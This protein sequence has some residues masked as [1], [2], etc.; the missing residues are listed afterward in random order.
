[1]YKI[2]HILRVL[3]IILWYYLLSFQ[4]N[5]QDT[6]TVGSS[7]IK[8]VGGVPFFINGSIINLDS[9][10]FNS[11]V[12]YVKGD[13]VNNHDGELFTKGETGKVILIGDSIQRIAGIH[14]IRFNKLI[15]N[16]P[17]TVKLDQDIILSDSAFFVRGILDLH[18]N[19]MLLDNS[20]LSVNGVL[21][22]EKDTS[23]IVGDSGYVWSQ[24]PL[25]NY[26]AKNGLGLGLILG[27]VSGGDLKIER[28]HTSELTVTDGSIKKYF[29]LYPS[30]SNQDAE[31]TFYY[32]DADLWGVNCTESDFKLWS[33]YTEGYYY[34]HKYGE[35][36]TAGNYAYTNGEYINLQNQVRIT[37][38]DEICDNPPNVNLGDDT[39]HVCYED[40]AVLDA[41]NPGYDFMWNTGATT[42]TIRVADAGMYIVTV[43][44]PK[45]CFTI[46]SIV[47][48]IDS[49]PHPGFDFAN[50]N[51]KCAGDT[52]LFTNNSTA[53][54]S[55]LPLSYQW[56]FGDGTVSYDSLPAKV[57]IAG[58][59]YEITL[60]AT[61]IN[62]CQRSVSHLAVVK[63][64]P[65]VDF[66]ADNVCFH[67]TV[68]F[69]NSTSGYIMN[70][71]WYFGDGDSST[72]SNPSHIYDTT[73]N[74]DV[75]LSVTNNYG[76][77]SSDTQT[78]AVYPPGTADFTT[79]DANVCY[80][81]S[82]V[83]HN[84]SVSPGGSMTYYWDFGNGLSSTVANPIILYDSVAT[85]DVMLV[86]ETEHGCKDT[87]IKQVTV[88][89]QPQPDFLYDDVCMG[90]SVYFTNASSIYPPEPMSFAWDF[91]DGTTSTDSNATKYYDQQGTYTVILS[92]TSSHGCQASVTKSVNVYPVPVANFTA[93]SVCYGEATVFHNLTYPD[94]VSMNF[95][96]DFGDGNTSNDEEPQHF[97]SSDGQYTVQ[98]IAV[99]GAG[100]SD[101]IVKQVKVF[102]VPVVDL[103]DTIYHCENSYV[104]NAGNPGA[105]YLWSTNAQSQEITV[106]N[107]GSY[108]VT[109]TNDYGCQAY[110][111]VQV[112][113]NSPVII[114][115]GGDTVSG[116]DMVVLDAGYPGADYLWSTGETTQTVQITSSGQYSVTV[117][118]QGCQGDTTVWVNVNPSPVVD[119]G[120]DMTVCEGTNVVLDAGNPGSFYAWSTGETSQTISPTESGTYSVEVT[121][122]YGCTSSDS[123]AVTFNP[124]PEVNFPD[125]TTVCGHVLL[126]AYNQ[127]ATYVWSNNSTDSAI[128]V[129][130][131]GLYWV[132]VTSGN[133]CSITDSVNVVVLPV[134]DINLGN[135]TA[136]CSGEILTLDGGSDAETYNWNTGDTS[137]Y[138]PVSTSGDYWVVATNQYN[139]ESSDTIHVTV[140]PVPNVNLGPDK[141]LC[142]N[143]PALLDAGDDGISYVWGSSGGFY[144][145]APIV[146]VS[147]SGTYWV[148]VTNEY[149][150]SASDTIRIDYSSYSITAHFLAPSEGKVGD[151]LQ[152]VDVSYPVPESYHWDFADGV[153]SVDSMPSHIYY[154]EGDFRVLLTVSNDFCSDTMSKVI[155]IEG[156]NKWFDN[157]TAN[158]Q[159]DGM[160]EIYLSRIYPNP[161]NGRFV[162]ELQ[163]NKPSEVYLYLYTLNGRLIYNEIIGNATYVLKSFD[164][165]K[166][167][168]G[169]YIFKM[170]AR[171][172][173]R[174]YK[175]IKVNN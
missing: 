145:T 148:D 118:N 34:E 109:V 41:G 103:G 114:D 51:Y 169:I 154:V 158:N 144:D 69:T 42:R 137:Q 25:D 99:S 113:L 23:R 85:Y 125:D 39:L 33:S 60:T 164:F 24:L 101:T 20:D 161:N 5:A 54:Q 116:C 30:I 12:I 175:I 84:T 35:V 115:L 43:T 89:P 11:G 142:A 141:F 66:E 68:N 52:F 22:G 16:K 46:D 152:F 104:L 168:S 61:G 63:P 79:E 74:Y 166:L 128:N 129:T 146:V 38:S 82:S 15:L 80:G 45:G 150:C 55:A 140:N 1:M 64:L 40:T 159:A 167:N 138:L 149:G 78:V 14:E 122:Q 95:Y 57:F 10:I 3:F 37:V 136:I 105:S 132:S 174:V 123:V 170:I 117:T 26:I 147:D 120:Q 9:S 90:D 27:N 75:I 81:N 49:V 98:L 31:V 106:Y 143:Q 53:D 48:V 173:T 111:T 8:L 171:D 72:V 19:D 18:G 172:Q 50:G 44:D 67:D 83:F 134:P 73:G 107:D 100:C 133:N 156:V 91:G 28:G 153:T 87:A 86:A 96:W 65:N 6:L 112:Y 32:L 58:G 131:S 155:H 47:V 102:P 160:F 94:D 71:I 93:D 88:Y 108:S 21:A 62:G 165:S 127:G 13:I 151:T 76:C 17:D 29:N 97:Y 124:L 36:D 163:I 2:Y 119:L 59:D 56:S 7:R 77:T 4:V 157:D 139:C 130:V 121:N 162:Y 126:S 135:D 110:D 70:Q 92:V